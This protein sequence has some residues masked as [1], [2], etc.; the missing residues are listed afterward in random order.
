MSLSEYL[1]QK[2]LTKDPSSADI[3]AKKKKRKKKGGGDGGGGGRG[4][5]GGMVIA[6]DDAMG[7]DEDGEKDVGGEGDDILVGELKKKLKKTNSMF[8]WPTITRKR[9]NNKAKKKNF[10]LL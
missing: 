1:A 6:D 2:Y 5:G 3:K 8:L 10:Y 7:W 4:G 9:V